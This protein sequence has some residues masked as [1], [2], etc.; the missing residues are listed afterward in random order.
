MAE[1]GS[2]KQ[3]MADKTQPGMQ[4]EMQNLAVYSDVDMSSVPS[5]PGTYIIL[6]IRLY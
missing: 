3:Q 1:G 5:M 4:H 6:L 2:L